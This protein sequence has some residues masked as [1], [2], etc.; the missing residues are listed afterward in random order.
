MDA[1]SA[2]PGVSRRK[3]SRAGYSSR[4]LK[5]RTEWAGPLCDRQGWAAKRRANYIILDRL[6]EGVSAPSCSA[7]GPCTA[8]AVDSDDKAVRPENFLPCLASLKQAY[9]C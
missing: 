6:P 1:E 9:M 2:V 4:P 5:R 8:T 7:P 3:P